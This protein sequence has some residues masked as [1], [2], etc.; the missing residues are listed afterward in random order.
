MRETFSAADIKALRKA[1]GLTQ[2]SLAAE[3]GVAVS[4]VNRWEQGV[5]KPS[6]LAVNILVMLRDTALNA[7]EVHA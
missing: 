3:V 2:E 1:L 7:R 4:T 6:R 5:A